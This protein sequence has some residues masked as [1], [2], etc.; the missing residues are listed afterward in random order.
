MPPFYEQSLWILQHFLLTNPDLHH[1]LL[2]GRVKLDPWDG[3]IELMK[4]A[5]VA[6][7]AAREKKPFEITSVIQNLIRK[8]ETDNAAKHVANNDGGQ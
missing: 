8:P 3:H 1:G 4:S 7:L 5:S 6:L 2:G